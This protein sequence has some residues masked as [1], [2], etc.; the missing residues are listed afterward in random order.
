MELLSSVFID[1]A[2]LPSI[3][4]VALSGAIGLAYDPNGY[5]QRKLFEFFG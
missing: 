3:R 5:D 1:W 4:D 2:R